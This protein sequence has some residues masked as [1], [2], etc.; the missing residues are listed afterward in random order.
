A[1][2]RSGS[3]DG[4]GA[5][6]AR[7]GNGGSAGNGGRRGRGAG[8]KAPASGR[9]FFFFAVIFVGG[10]NRRMRWIVGLGN[11]GPAYERT[12]HNAGFMV[13]DELARRWNA[14]LRPN[15]RCRALLGEAR[16]GGV[17]VALL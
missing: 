6:A 11:P 1:G 15:A 5:A 16:V 3:G 10:G 4:R 7:R 8:V 14:D 2:G 9:D 17:R 12:R 13:V